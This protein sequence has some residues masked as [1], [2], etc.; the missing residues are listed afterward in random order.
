MDWVNGVATSQKSINL[1]DKSYQS[2]SHLR[3]TLKGYLNDLDAF[4]RGV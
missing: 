3:S 2:A 1:A 4:N